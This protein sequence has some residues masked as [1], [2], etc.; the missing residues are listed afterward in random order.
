MT[1]GQ[2]IKSLWDA[3]RDTWEIHEIT[4]L[5]ESHIYNSLSAYRKER[6]S[7]YGQHKILPSLA[8]QDAQP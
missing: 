4:G 2:V 5:P 8:E 1:D 6:Y 3:G 7:V